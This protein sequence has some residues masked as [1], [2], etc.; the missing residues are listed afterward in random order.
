MSPGVDGALWVATTHGIWKVNSDLSY[1]RIL[2]RNF[3]A[4]IGNVI[5][6]P[7]G[8]FYFMEKYPDSGKIFQWR[9]GKVTE[10]VTLKDNLH[11][12]VRRG[13]TL[14]ANGDLHMVAFRPN[15]E[16]EVLE[17]GRD[18]PIGGE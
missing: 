13:E 9:D 4:Y 17:A 2:T 18:A 7:D 8:S 12:F 5:A 6:H 14:W 16:P 1:Q 11:D 3:N 10:R 15:R